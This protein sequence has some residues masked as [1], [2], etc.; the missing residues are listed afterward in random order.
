MIPT[1][2]LKIQVCGYVQELQ[3]S[4]QQLEDGMFS[5]WLL[6]ASIILT[7]YELGFSKVEN[8]KD[9]GVR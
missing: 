8:D 3:R 2:H 9:E 7:I 6:V 1:S 5:L 4:L